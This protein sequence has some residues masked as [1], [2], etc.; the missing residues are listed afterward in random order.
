MEKLRQ[1]PQ[2]IEEIV[3]S[4]AQR[5]Q[6]Y[7]KEF[8]PP[9]PISDD[10]VFCDVFQALLKSTP[11]VIQEIL[12]KESELGAEVQQVIAERDRNLA[13]FEEA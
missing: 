13:L 8:S 2:T 5:Y 10:D 12:T 4:I 7:L 6:K 1:N 3:D 9:R 11:A